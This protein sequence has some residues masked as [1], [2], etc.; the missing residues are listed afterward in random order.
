MLAFDHRVCSFARF[1][2]ILLDHETKLKKCYRLSLTRLYTGIKGQTA[3]SCAKIGVVPEDGETLLRPTRH[4]GGN[5]LPQ[6]WGN[7][8]KMLFVDNYTAGH[9][10]GCLWNLSLPQ[11]P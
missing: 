8:L 2:R 5:G 7:A 6:A 1:F 11:K 10:L 9:R 4:L 3:E